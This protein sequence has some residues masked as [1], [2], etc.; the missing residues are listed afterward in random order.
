MVKRT[1]RSPPRPLTLIAG[2]AILVA[3]V[4]LAVVLLLG[5]DVNAPTITPPA[6]ISVHAQFD[7]ATPE[8]GDRIDAKI[9]IALNSRSVRPQTLRYSYGLSP[10]TQLEAPRTSRYASGDLELITLVAPVTCVTAPCVA[11]KGVTTLTFPAVTAT[12]MTTKGA[13][14]NATAR[15][16]ALP[17]R[18][19][20]LASDLASSSPKFQGNASPPT[21]SYSVAPSTLATLLD[22]LAA[23]CAVG[24]VALVAWQAVVIIR[25]RPGRRVDPLERALRLAR[26]AENQP[27]PHRRRAAGLL[28]RLLGRDRLSSTANDLAWSEHN[29][30]P[31]ELEAL[32]SEIERRTPR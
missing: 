20:V 23:L 2:L 16:P 26:E 29:P 4:A 30:E 22:V 28:A 32:V 14:Q 7:P 15:W 12:V 10:L 8:F 19:R 13:R 9:V 27:V 25:R 18:G 11:R 6:T 5:A 3:A 17:I 21:P 24:A 31:D 1:L